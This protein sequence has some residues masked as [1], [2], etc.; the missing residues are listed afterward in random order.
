MYGIGA[1]IWSLGVV[2]YQM[3]TGEYPYKG[4]SRIDLL[5]NITNKTADLSNLKISKLAKDF[6][7]GCLTYDTK[8]R[9][10]WM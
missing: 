7:Q 6:I 1:D 8:K 9:I 10:S 5:K 4:K 3:L 2:F